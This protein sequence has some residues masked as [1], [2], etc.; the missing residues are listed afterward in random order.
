MDTTN[1][2]KALG[3]LEGVTA[4]IAHELNRA[5]ES[6]HLLSEGL[7][8]TMKAAAVSLADAIKRADAYSKA[9]QS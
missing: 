9:S 4:A 2:A 5:A 3:H 7:R 6:P 8:N 1:Y